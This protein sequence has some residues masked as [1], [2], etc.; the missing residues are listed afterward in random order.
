VLTE[1]GEALHR[2]SKIL[3]ERETIDRDQFLRL[4]SGEEEELVWAATQKA[5]TPDVAEPRRRESKSRGILPLP[6]ALSPKPAE[7]DPGGA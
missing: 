5:D 2:L 6:G 3:V 1:H 7:P 4:L